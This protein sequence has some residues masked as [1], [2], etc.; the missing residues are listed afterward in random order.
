MR[1]SSIRRR[2]PVGD[3]GR[4]K[5]VDQGQPAGLARGVDSLDPAGEMVAGGACADLDADRILDTPDVLHVR[6]AGLIGAKADPGEVGGQVEEAGPARD[7]AG[8]RLFVTQVERFVRREEID[9]IA[10]AG[11]DAE[12][13][14]HEYQRVGD[15]LRHG[16]VLIGHGRVLHPIEV[17]V[18]GMVEVGKAA[19]DQR[20]D[21]VQGEGRALVTAQQKL[22]IGRASFESEV[23]TVDDIAAVRGK[24][25]AVA[26]LVV[27]GARLGV[28]AGEAPDTGDRFLG[29]DHQHQAHLQQHFDSVGDPYG[30]AVYQALGA[31]ARLQ[32]ET[33]SGRG[34]GK[35][36]AQIHDLPT[37]HQGRELPEIVEDPFESSQIGILGLLQGRPGA[38]GR[39]APFRNG[40]WRLKR[41]ECLP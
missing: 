31:V 27:G 16:V 23:R 18:F 22:R 3:A 26:R 34:F 28:L 15:G 4:A 33:A 9:P 36:F 37:G 32:H 6:A 7:A 25:D 2:E 5:A 19:L 13:I 20:A 39:R 35:L 21:E 12:N 40:R 29:P 30:A 24:R 41:H 8:L 10:L 11:A 17:E 1:T 14:L 38:P